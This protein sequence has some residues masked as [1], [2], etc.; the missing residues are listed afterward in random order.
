MAK[1]KDKGEVFFSRGIAYNYIVVIDAG[2]SGSR[3]HIYHY[4]ATNDVAKLEELH[5]KG[6]HL[7]HDENDPLSKWTTFPR[8]SKSGNK[9]H[10]KIN[11]G[12]SSFANNPQDI[13]KEHIKKLVKYAEEIIPKAQIPRTPVFVYATGGLRL[14]ENS[15]SHAILSNACE[16][17]QK[18]TKFFLPDCASHLKVIDGAT[19]GLFGWL[20]LN[21]LIGGIEDPQSHSH[22]KDHSTY[23]FL[24]MGGASMQIAFVPNATEIEE[25]KAELYRIALASLD[26][27]QDRM[28]DIYS[29]SFLGAGVNEARKTYLKSLTTV[30]KDGDIEDP[31]APVGLKHSEIVKRDLQ[32]VD[33]EEED[34]RDDDE[35]EDDDDDDD[36]DL[37][38]DDD[39]DEDDEEEDQD[40]EKNDKSDK[41]DKRPKKDDKENKNKSDKKIEDTKDDSDKS[42]DQSDKLPPNANTKSYIGTG[43]YEACRKQI[44]PILSSIKNSGSPDFD[45]EINHFVGVSEYFDTPDKGFSL[46]GSFDYDSLNTK[47][48]QFCGSKWD[49]IN[50]EEYP[51]LSKENL[52]LLCFKSS[53]LLGVVDEGFQFPQ[54]ADKPSPADG[55]VNDKVDNNNLTT[56]LD[57]LQSAED[58]N[59]VEFSWTLGPALLYAAGELSMHK[60]SEH[61]GIQLNSGSSSWQYGG[62]VNGY[63]RPELRRQD[64]DDDDDEASWGEYFDEHSHRLYGSIIFLLILVV[65]VYLLLGR[66]RRKLILQ[67][68][69]SRF[70]NFPA[71]GG[72]YS[73]VSGPTRR[74]PS[75]QPEDFE[76]QDV[77][78]GFDIASDDEEANVRGQSP[79]VE[80]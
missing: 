47:V 6:D 17:I 28:Y 31:C 56:Y 18:E 60:R 22:G 42:G 7:A 21:Y 58:I 1:S 45:F 38:D 46:G 19:E 49:S 41:G 48:E 9:W 36:D 20:G 61:N 73:L 76:L 12:M 50:P 34:E 29:K 74:N 3:I 30:N 51:Q 33:V 78:D 53:Y 70:K 37:E 43:N 65:A 44:S 66:Q 57:P 64:L 16:Y 26:G 13:G 68:L 25:N 67:S 15:Q 72:Q 40:D 11:P 62:E 27:T 71:K 8:V 35:D 80:V 59:G 52:E 32:K 24:D 14:L 55:E 63:T 54:L 23:G 2:S 10:K 4:P 39:D 69:V 75:P 77:E 79:H 5:N